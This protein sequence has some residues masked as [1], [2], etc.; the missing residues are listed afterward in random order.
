MFS[1]T[2]GNNFLASWSREIS[3]G[4]LDIGISEIVPYWNLM[5]NS[6]QIE[7][8]LFPFIVFLSGGKKSLFKEFLQDVHFVEFIDIN[9]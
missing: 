3:Q 1:Q 9:I 7:V 4:G 5:F 2:W 6:E 8:P